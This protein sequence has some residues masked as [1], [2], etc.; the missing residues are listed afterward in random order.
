MLHRLSVLAAI[1]TISATPAL[2]Q[3][4]P[5]GTG[6][7]NI[8]FETIPSGVDLVGPGGITL[9]GATL[10]TQPLTVQGIIESTTGGIRFPDGT[11]Q[12]TA[13]VPLNAGPG[14]SALYDNRIP[15]LTPDQAYSE[16]CF[17]DGRVQVDSH[18]VAEATAGGSCEPGDLGW[19][20]EKDERPAA[21]WE[22][23][24][25]QCLLRGMRLPE[26]FEWRLSCVEA[27]AFGLHDMVG[28]WEWASNAPTPWVEANGVSGTSVS[29]FGS[30]GCG[31]G[32]QSWL[33]SSDN[34]A[35]TRTFRCVL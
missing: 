15:D 21:T 3:G 24:R 12:T 7:Q 22:A 2:A 30:S 19:I 17:K 26:P 16:V 20:I 14:G 33:G 32:T 4:G 8:P 9:D 6:I 18:P 28:N 31:H 23:A 25:V 11:V 35:E 5:E 29:A 27:E 1:L 13:A 34:A 10:V